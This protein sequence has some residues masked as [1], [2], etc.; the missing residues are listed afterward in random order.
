MVKG[1][2]YPVSTKAR[3]GGKGLQVSPMSGLVIVVKFW[4]KI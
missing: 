4:M 1:A 2:G 3:T